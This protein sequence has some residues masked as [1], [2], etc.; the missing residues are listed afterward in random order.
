MAQLLKIETEDG[1]DGIRIIRLT[2]PFILNNIFEFQTL[3]RQ[4][5]DS[6]ILL[7]LSGVPYMDSAGLGVLIGLLVSCHRKGRGFGVTGVAERIMTLFKVAGVDGTIPV[8][9]SIEAAKSK[10]VQATSA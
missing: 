4:Q 8:F 7:D 6:T 5:T 3:A 10:L 1:A 2:G 9:D